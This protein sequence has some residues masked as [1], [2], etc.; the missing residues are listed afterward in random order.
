MCYASWR[1]RA[2]RRAGQP[3]GKCSRSLHCS[4]CCWQLDGCNLLATSR[5]SSSLGSWFWTISH[6]KANHWNFFSWTPYYRTKGSQSDIETWHMKLQNPYSFS[7][8]SLCLKL[9]TNINRC[10]LSAGII[11]KKWNWPK[12]CRKAPVSRK[13]CQPI[14]NVCRF[15]WLH[16]NLILLM[17]DV[18]YLSV[19]SSMMFVSQ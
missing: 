11:F 17:L 2:Q 19:K 7:L 8:I 13:L 16:Y 5:L 1:G 12:V 6:R 14:I 10:K 9:K 4:R 15:L 3:S 18:L